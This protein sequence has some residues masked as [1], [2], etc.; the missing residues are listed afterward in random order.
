LAGVTTLQTGSSIS[1]PVIHGLHSNRILIMNNGVRQEGQQWG[2]EHAPEIDPFIAT[3]LSVVKGAAGV[4]Y[5]SDAIGGVILVEP[6]ELPFDK[7]LSGEAECGGIHEWSTGCFVWYCTGWNKG[8]Q[9][10]WMENAGND[11][12]G[13]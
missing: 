2:S 8:F 11:Q 4:R 1:K 5:G 12:T 3:R 7:S 13:R 6:E 10:I 9:G